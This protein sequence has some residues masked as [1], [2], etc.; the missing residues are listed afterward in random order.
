MK[1]LRYSLIAALLL[2]SGCSLTR[3]ETEAGRNKQI[4]L[5]ALMALDTAQTVTIGRSPECLY[6]ANPAA[7]ALF[8]SDTP[9]PERVL[10]TNAAYIAAHWIA[11]AYLDRK[12]EAPI[13][14]TVDAVED[15]KRRESWRFKRTLYQ[16]FT[17]F[18]HG[19]AV[20]SNASRGI[21]PFSSYEC[22]R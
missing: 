4:A 7:A 14:F 20:A 21:K 3:F 10:Y 5:T 11:A 2:T 8:G 22:G 13:D 16:F 19:V 18:G 12:A 9:S 6:E 17:T 15:V 1:Y